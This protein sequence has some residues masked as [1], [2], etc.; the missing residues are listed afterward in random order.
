MQQLFV[1]VGTLCTF[2]LQY[3]IDQEKES[4]WFVDVLNG[5]LLRC[6]QQGEYIDIANVFIDTWHVIYTYMHNNYLKYNKL[7]VDRIMHNAKFG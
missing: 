2:S 6:T 7:S 1:C 5:C 3:S 4:Q